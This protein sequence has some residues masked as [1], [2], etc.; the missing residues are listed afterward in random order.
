M[1][2][3]YIFWIVEKSSGLSLKMD[4]EYMDTIAPQRDK[5]QW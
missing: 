4:S 1:L 3:N 2:I 5:L